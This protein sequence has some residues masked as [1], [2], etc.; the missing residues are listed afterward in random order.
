[1]SSAFHISLAGSPETFLKGV[2]LAVTVIPHQKSIGY[3]EANSV[4]KWTGKVSFGEL[5]SSKWIV[6]DRWRHELCKYI[7]YSTT[8]LLPQR[9]H[10]NRTFLSSG[11]R[12]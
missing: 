11:C 12:T 2:H 4:L 9:F 6:P 5:H 10:Q 7:S 3:F 8:Q 1:M